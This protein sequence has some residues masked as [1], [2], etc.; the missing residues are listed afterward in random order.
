[1]ARAHPVGS[2]GPAPGLNIGTAVERR[3]AVLTGLAAAEPRHGRRACQRRAVDGCSYT[4]G[5]VHLAGCPLLGRASGARTREH[6][7]H[8]APSGKAGASGGHGA[9]GRAVAVSQGGAS[10]P[11]EH[12]RAARG[13]PR[14]SALPQPLPWGLPGFDNVQHQRDNTPPSHLII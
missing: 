4:S 10:L 1:M 13:S 3:T 7:P 8:C 2:P 5:A 9:V 12:C 6:G 14:L 11:A